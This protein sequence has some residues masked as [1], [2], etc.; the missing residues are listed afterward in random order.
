MSDSNAVELIKRGDGRFSKRQQLDSFRQ[1]IALNFA[2]WHASWTSQLQWGEDF[3]SHLVDGTPLLL[4][5]DYIGQI[6]AMLRPPGKQWF[7][8]RTG[9]EQ[10]D[11]NRGIREY[12]DWRSTYMM[13]VMTDRPTGF[14]RATKQ[15]DEFFGLFGDAVISVDTDH[16]QEGL[17]IGT[18]HTKDCVWAIGPENKA[19]AVTRKEMVSARNFV[20]RFAQKG[21]KIHEK[22]KEAAEK[23]PDQEF[24]I[25]HEVLPADEYDAFK[26]PGMSRQSGQFASVWVDVTNRCIIRETTTRTMRYVVPRSVTLPGNPY[27]IS[28]ATIIALPDARLIQQQAL[29]ILEA[30]EKSVNPPLLA[31]QDAVRGD[32]SFQANG[33]TWL[34]KSYD[35]RTGDAIKPMEIGKNFRLGVE[36]LLRTEAQLT[37]AFYLD[38]LRMPDTRNSKSTLEVQFKID[39]YVR[40]S[41]PLFAPMQAEYNESLLAEVDAVISTIGGYD[42]EMPAALKKAELTYS[43]DNPLSDMVERQKAQK[44]SEV[45][46]LANTI[47]GL[48]AAAS[49][50]KSLRHIETTKML[51]ESVMGIGAPEWLVDEDDA[52]EAAAADA[53]A[54]QMQQMVAAA[55]NIA[56]VIDSG[57]SAAQAA[58]EIPS[59][60]EPGFALPMPA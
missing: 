3:A 50:A 8:H 51:R 34:D 39:E 53:K 6:G 27:G 54:A 9:R 4:A 5:R 17:R 28:M 21:D 7:W 33:I 40:A 49:Q 46:S 23:N 19:N 56:Q 12:L 38:V 35:E 60:A 24:E 36:S 1:E 26:K 37:K 43:W 22:I 45:A 30:A 14:F 13:R 48:E 55:P 15:A 42:R 58:S 20:V 59:Q 25:R 10:L 29:A 16:M 2:P 11:N 47:A 57:V 44:V 41:L 32:M 52:N 18:F 31:V